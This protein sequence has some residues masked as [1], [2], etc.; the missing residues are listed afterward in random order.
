MK[1]QELIKIIE[2]VVRKE[3][4]KQMNEIFIKD[5]DSSSLTE[6]V[7]KPL[8]EKEFKEP[9]R[10]Q[11]KSK[12]EVNY[13]SNKALNKVLNE[14]VGGVPQGESGEYPTM[15]GGVYDSS[16]VND[17]LARETGL[18]NPESVKEKKRE[19]AAVDSIKKAGVNVDQ[20]P[21]HV[22]DALTKD[23]S[24]VMKAIDQKKGGGTNY[25]P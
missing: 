18:G 4:K 10:K 1:K 12:K 15:G 23:Y 11:Y 8:T 20:V 2:T 14:T 6:L 3:V 16:K 24:A 5:N 9:I 17:L 21:D 7:S 25:R 22:Q 13:T 19:I